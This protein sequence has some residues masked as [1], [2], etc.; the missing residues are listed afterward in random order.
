MAIPGVCAAPLPPRRLQPCAPSSLATAPDP[1]DQH[2]AGSTWT[3]S[4]GKQGSFCQPRTSP[5]VLSR[6]ASTG[7][8]HTQAAWGGGVGGSPAP[9]QESGACIGA[10]VPHAPPG[11]HWPH[12]FPH[13]RLGASASRAS[14][15]HA[16]SGRCSWHRPRA[17]PWRE[18]GAWSKQD[19]RFHT[20]NSRAERGGGTVAPAPPISSLPKPGPQD[21]SP[22]HT[23]PEQ[24]CSPR[25][26][27]L[28]AQQWC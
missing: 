8:G 1:G 11:D 16:H 9:V 24:G 12:G 17:A 20:P 22:T 4:L 27:V 7:L 5:L 15:T 18:G 19:R 23:G 10:G 3:Q 6:P 13:A 26:T 14:A 21:G 2:M 25:G 28:G